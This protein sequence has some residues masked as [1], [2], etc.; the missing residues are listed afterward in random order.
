MPQANSTNKTTAADFGMTISFSI[1]VTLAFQ[2]RLN[3]GD[4]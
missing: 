2:T 3:A 1:T 4:P